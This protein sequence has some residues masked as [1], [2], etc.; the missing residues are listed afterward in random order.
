LKNKKEEHKVAKWFLLGYTDSA[1]PS[2]EEEFNKWY[3]EI[4]LPDSLKLPG[5][6]SATRYVNTDP[7]AGPGKFLA[8]YEI[9]SEDIDKTMGVVQENMGK[10]REQGRISELLVIVSIATYRQI[11]YLAR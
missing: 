2:R 3:D 6:I 9:E 8:I 5:F 11:S 7:N 1:D 4:H 10:L